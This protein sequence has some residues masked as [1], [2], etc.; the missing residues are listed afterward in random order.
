MPAGPENFERIFL[1]GFMGSGKTT[2]ASL[3]A[4][5]IG[6]KFIDTDNLIELSTS[7]KVSDIFA[8][9]GESFFRKIEKK[10]I[11]DVCHEKKVV[12]ALGGGALM[13]IENLTIIENCGVLVWLKVSLQ[14]ALE[15]TSRGENR[16]LRNADNATLKKLY[17]NRLSGYK[18]AHI[19]INAE[20]EQI[21]NTELILKRI[22]SNYEFSF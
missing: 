8:Q 3:L 13:D 11:I 1:T 5:K 6:W 9:N 20:E 21:K 2:I 7:K 18:K 14:T 22:S 19:I 4:N 15:R 16:P 12:I 17:S 10:T